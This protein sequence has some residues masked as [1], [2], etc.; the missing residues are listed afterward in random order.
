[1]EVYLDDILVKS[2]RAEDHVT[3]LAE[4]FGILRLYKLKLQPLEMRIWSQKRMLLMIGDR[5]GC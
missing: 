1:M 4:T 2:R 5:E 3:G